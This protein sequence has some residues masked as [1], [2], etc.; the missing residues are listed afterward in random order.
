MYSVNEPGK[1]NVKRGFQAG[2]TAEMEDEH[3]FRPD[4]NQTM[5]S[6]SEAFAVAKANFVKLVGQ[7]EP[8]AD[9]IAQEAE[10]RRLRLAKR[11]DA[12]EEPVLWSA[13]RRRT[14]RNVTS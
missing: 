11:S 3:V 10:Q 9:R 5:F 4:K 12:A 1:K 14:S 8:V 7:V 13:T 6:N 2:L